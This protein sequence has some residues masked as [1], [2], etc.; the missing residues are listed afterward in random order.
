M[1][2]KYTPREINNLKFSIPLYQRLFEWESEQILQLLNDLFESYTKNPKHPYYIGMLT[3]FEEPDL[4]LSLVDGQQR[5]TI[6]TLMAIALQNY[7]PNWLKFIEFDNLALR[8]SFYA[9]D[10]DYDYLIKKK[11]NAVFSG[12]DYKN[13]KMENGLNT[14]LDFFDKIDSEEKVEFAEYIF[15]NATFFLSHLPETYKLTDLNRYFESMNATGRSLENHEILK[16]SLLK[17]IDG[18]KKVFYTQ[19][20]NAVSEMDKCLVRPESSKYENVEDLKRRRISALQNLENIEKLQD[21]CND[22]SKE[23][24]EN[25]ASIESIHES[26]ISPQKEIKTRSERSIIKFSEFLL[27][28]LWLQLKTD[29]KETS[30]DFF[31]LNKLQETFKFNLKDEGVDLFF[32]NILKYRVL[33]DYF[34]LRIRNDEESI[35]NYFLNSSQDNKEDENILQF[36][37]M[38]Y[39]STSYYLW[40]TPALEFIIQNPTEIKNDQLIAFL[41]TWDNKERDT[42]IKLNY[43]SINRY[44]FWRLDYYLWESRSKI[45]TDT[46]LKIANQYQFRVNRSIEHVA[47]QTLMDGNRRLFDEIYSDV[48]GNLTMISTGQNSFLKNE[49]FE[50]KRAHVGAF[51]MGSKIGSIESLKMMDIYKYTTWNTENLFIHHNKMIDLLIESFG[52]GY[53]EVKKNLEN[54]RL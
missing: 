13:S 53:L 25:S 43:G 16:V 48:F 54:L 23:L 5:F 38:L 52:E 31:N 49:S 24:K 27:Q 10:N 32:E 29:K 51:V 26:S 44:W 45:F 9:R 4:T 28:I 12:S 21:Y 33:F 37:S 30:S 35:K 20:W 14:I 2:Q 17:K 40:L 41:K 42:L 18:S 50:V 19:I 46:H 1:N 3:V 8:I 36:Q 6:L 15:E 39:V 34:I 22:F 11:N 7:E 47:P